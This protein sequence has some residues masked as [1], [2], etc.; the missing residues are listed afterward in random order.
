MIDMVVVIK[1]T[2]VVNIKFYFKWC[3]LLELRNS[4]TI[5]DFIF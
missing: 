5:K 4:N 1:G 3:R 2:Y